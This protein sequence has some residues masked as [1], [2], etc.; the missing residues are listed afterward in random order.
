[1]DI[2]VNEF[3]DKLINTM[4]MGIKIEYNKYNA[5]DGSLI[6]SITY[7]YDDKGNEIEN[8]KFNA[9]GYLKMKFN[10]KFNY[11]K[12]NNWINKIIVLDGIPYNI[13]EREIVYY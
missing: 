12:N 6:E 4:I 9:D 7:K 1:M 2:P 8:S 3:L 10:Y 13:T 11:D 5:D